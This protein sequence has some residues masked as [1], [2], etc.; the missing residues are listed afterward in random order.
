MGCNRHPP[1]FL[2]PKK[3]RPDDRYLGCVHTDGLPDAKQ[4]L[5]QGI[6]EDPEVAEVRRE[7]WA[8]CMKR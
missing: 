3:P 6:V 5:R 4:S 2:R 1:I 7:V 8:K